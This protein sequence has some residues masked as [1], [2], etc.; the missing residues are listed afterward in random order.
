MIR[1]G[2]PVAKIRE[3]VRNNGGVLLTDRAIQRVRDHVF[4]LKDVYDRVLAEELLSITAESSA[5]PTDGVSHATVPERSETTAPTGR[6]LV[7]DDD[8]DSRTLVQRALES[9]AYD[10][11]VAEDGASALVELGKG[12]FDLLIA[13]IEMP[14]LDGF[15]LLQVVGAQGIDV[16]VIFLTGSGLPEDEARG[17][18]L[19]AADYILKPMRRDVLLARVA[20]TLAGRPV[21]AA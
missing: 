7:V 16:P 9:A 21:A 17:L 8:A 12:T 19:G 5:V 11:V 2:Q 20:K 18:S 10:V 14:M 15:S 4:A 13:D 6:I 1:A 3:T